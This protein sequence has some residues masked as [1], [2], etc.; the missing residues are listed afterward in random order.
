MT[1]KEIVKGHLI[2]NGYDG[3][4]HPGECS[5][6]LSDLMPCDEGFASVCEPGFIS[7]C[8]CGGDCDFHIGRE[9]VL[10]KFKDII[11]LYTEEKE[12]KP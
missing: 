11:G 7:A 4:L 5:C 3:L 2:K 6:K 10:P 12:D 9:K 1:V 8:D